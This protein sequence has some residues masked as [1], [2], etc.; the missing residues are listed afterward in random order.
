MSGLMRC[1]V[2]GADGTFGGTLSRS[3]S[4][5]GHAVITTTR[6][7]AH[8][9]KQVSLF[10]DLAGQLPVMPEVD[11]AVICAAMSRFED[12]RREPELARRVNVTAPLELGQALTKAGARIIFL[13]TSAVFDCREPHSGEERKPSPRSA[14]GHLKAEAE[15]RLM[16]LGA[17]VSVLR[18]TKVV[19]PNSG[20]LSDWIR[21]L[22]HRGKVRAIE[23][24]HFCPLAVDHVVAAIVDLAEKGGDGIYH[25]SGAADVSYLDA[26]HFLA[27]R[28]GV[29]DDRIEPVR[30]A[31]NG[32]MEAERALFTSLATRRL[33]ELAGFVPPEPFDV[34]QAVY[35]PE[36]D[37]ARN[38]PAVY[39]GQS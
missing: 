8:A 38:A 5:R 13:S 34:L 24:H 21:S 22:G 32:L 30:G 23:D 10:L 25:V 3:L 16:D 17:L 36:I 26:A 37:A 9:A 35:G 6:R 1:L 11:V 19:T 7:T 33:T 14:Y 31:D 27:R 4:E 29:S 20:I 28:I 2:I 15:A 39:A 12:C 18:L